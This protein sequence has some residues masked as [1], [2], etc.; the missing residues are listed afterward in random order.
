MHLDPI[1]PR[2]VAAVFV[3]LV[4]GLVLRRLR[5]P[6]VIVYLLA[7]I[8]LGPFGLRV[9][10]NEIILA[11]VGDF[12]V[13]LLL[14]FVGMEV[15]LASLLKS[16]RV[17]ILGT[18]LQVLAS[19]GFVAVIG[20]FRDWSLARV[21]LI[22]FAISLSSTAVV[23]SLLRSRNELDSATG[24]DALGVLLIQDLALIPMLIVLGF[25]GGAPPTGRELSLQATAQ[26]ADPAPTTTYSCC[27][28]RI[29]Q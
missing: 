17:S 9:F 7:G 28:A 22:G 18:L 14:F 8:A 3:L 21:L 2:I 5:Q 13:V 1:L 26:P 29:S 19:V 23:V 25:L 15:S 12:G 27:I 20:W 4:V 16:W 10:T 6:H 24:R 11:R